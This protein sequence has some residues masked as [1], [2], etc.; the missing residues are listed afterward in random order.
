MMKLYQPVLFVGLG[1]TGCNIGAVVERRLREEICGPDGTEFRN[2]RKN[3]AL[4]P[5]QLPSC[6]QFVYADLNQADLNKMPRR[7]V[8]GSQHMPAA[9]A[10]AHYVRDLAPPVASYSQLAV[11]L[12][13][14]AEQETESWLPP[15]RSEPK[16]SPL[17]KGAGQLPTIGRAALFGTFLGSIDPALRDLRTA[18]GN[19]ATSAEDLVALGG[20]APRAVD[21]FVAF[22]LAGGTGAGIFYDYLHLIGYL[23]GNRLPAK[24]YPLVLMPSGFPRG[25]GGGRPADLNAA[26]G[27][28][29][30]FR[31]V[32]HQNTGDAIRDLH[33]D[34]WAAGASPDR[35]SVHYPGMSEIMLSPGMIQTGFLFSQPMGADRVDL[36]RSIG[37]LV[38]SLI[39]TDLEPDEDQ[40]G[41][42]HQTFADWW[43]NSGTYRQVPADNGIGNRG[44]STALVAS[45]TVPVDDLAGLIGGRL[46]RI[47]IEQLAA[48]VGKPESNHGY[49]EDFLRAANVHP[50]FAREGTPFAEPEP[51]N[52]A[53]E[54]ATGLNDRGEAMT[55]GLDSLQA[56][57]SRDVPTYVN[58]FDPRNGVA[59]LLG[60][61]DV[62]RAQ[63][64]VFGQSDL[65][66]EAGQ[67]SAAGLLRRRE[68]PPVAPNGFGPVPPTSSEY[69]NRLAGL[70][71]VKWA[72]KEPVAVRG[73]QDAWYKWRTNVT[74]AHAWAGH[75]P[76]WRRTLADAEA[77]LAGLTDALLGFTQQERERFGPRADELYRRRVGVSY[78]LPPGGTGMEQFY[79]LTVKRLIDDQVS[80]GNLQPAATE[81]DLVRAMLGPDAWRDTYQAAA[82]HG[83]AQAVDDLR[84]RVKGIV[85][86]FLRGTEGGKRPLLPRLHD[87]LAAAAGQRLPTPPPQDYV[88]EFRGKVA[89]LVPATFTPQGSGQMKVLVSYPADAKSIAIE[90]YLRETINLPP[91]P[92]LVYDM[93]NTHSESLSVALFRSSMG[94]TEVAEVREVLRLWASALT[95]PERADFLRWRQR[96]GY[97]FAYLATTETHRVE[98]LHR[99][100][101]AMWNGRVTPDGPAASPERVHVEFGGGV[102]MILSL[103]PLEQASSWGSLLRAYELW[104][105]NEED[106]HRQFC[107]QLMAE[108]PAGLSGGYRQPARLL[109]TLCGLAD[110]EIKRLDAVITELPA[111][112]Q[113]RAR[114]MRQFWAETL[115]AALDHE[116][117]GLEAPARANLRL[118]MDAAARQEQG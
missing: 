98:I 15:D 90:S 4:L 25:L 79:Q 28:L 68:R 112:S 105:L 22:S 74:W 91:E 5:Y 6:V 100:L 20:R 1:G 48:P 88:E 110:G 70:I 111:N 3:S 40:T 2:R 73:R 18:I 95:K 13:L 106:I 50:V 57:L 14:A 115:P 61:V 60:S 27:L 109:T 64:A 96:T 103:T 11:K 19:L 86:V 46:L 47:A 29:D 34:D 84:D 52:G 58:R 56:K 54:I 81:A 17:S 53:H 49:A 94:V 117:T 78:L 33:G 72:D 97:Q 82:E 24:I 108:L 55:R 44:V 76:Q 101:C 23:C 59:E 67:V 36:H 71:K 42:E 41:E 93:K 92:E 113:G 16:I 85:K 26:R 30:L 87:L 38:L 118:L 9:Q 37:S 114:Q 63:R 99:L 89:G 45:L 65:E 35:Q 43:V 31:L 80:S 7:V 77:E 62:F 21:V 39:G 69:R 66:N 107:A 116:F 32:D 51:R 83:P 75:A 102:T 104:T 12:R 8:P 10:T